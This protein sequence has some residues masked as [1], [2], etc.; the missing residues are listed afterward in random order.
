MRG[1][2]LVIKALDSE[3]P[4]A[5]EGWARQAHQFA[6]ASGDLDLELCAASQVGA[7]LV[8]LGRVTEGLTWLDESM[9]GSLG[10]GGASPGTVVWTSCNMIVSCTRSAQFERVVQWVHAADSFTQRYGCP[11][12]Y[13]E[14]RTHYGGVLFATGKWAQ[15]ERELRVALE[16][17]RD[18]IPVHHRQALATLSEL[19]LAQ[20]RIEEAER[21]VSG[22]DDHEAA[23][24]VWA[25]THLLRGKPA[26]AAATARRRLATVGEDRLESALLLESLGEAEIDQGDHRAAAKRGRKLAKLGET[27]GYRFAA[28]RGQHRRPNGHLRVHGLHDALHDRLAG[29]RRRRSRHRLGRRAGPTD[30]G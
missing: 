2:L 13:S 1:W 28:P 6:R 29:P 14:C 7:S 8:R 4:E 9:A 16:L 18:A 24:P 22:L 23:A 10:E 5:A 26:L 12:L 20:G 19:R 17:S 3:E 15:A 11:Y 27:S 25:R 30:A 21:L